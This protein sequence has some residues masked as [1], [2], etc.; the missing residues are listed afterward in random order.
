M[1]VAELSYSEASYSRSILFFDV[2][3]LV[4]LVWTP[5]FF[6][7]RLLPLPWEGALP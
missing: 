2:S 1:R 5:A 6:K 4:E 7:K 3:V